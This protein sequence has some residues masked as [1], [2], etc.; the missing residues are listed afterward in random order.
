MTHLNCHYCKKND[1]KTEVSGKTKAK[2]G[3]LIDYRICHQCT[4][5][6]SRFSTNHEKAQRNSFLEKVR[7]NAFK[8]IK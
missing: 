2:S 5:V 3:Q 7:A 1:F 4:K 6:L 8:E